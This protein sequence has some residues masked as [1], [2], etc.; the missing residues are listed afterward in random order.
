MNHLTL[1]KQTISNS[2]F[3]ADS[4]LAVQHTEAKLS[5]DEFLKQCY[6]ELLRKRGNIDHEFFFD[7]Y[8][9]GSIWREDFELSNLSIISGTTHFIYLNFFEKPFLENE[10]Q[11]ICSQMDIETIQI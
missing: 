5:K 10:I 2:S 3:S 11:T 8:E 7:G 1:I 4:F 9:A 6:I